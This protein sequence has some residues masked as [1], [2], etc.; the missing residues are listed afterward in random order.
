MKGDELAPAALAVLKKGVVAQGD[1]RS[2]AFRIAAVVYDKFSTI[3]VD[4]EILKAAATLCKAAKSEAVVNI[5]FV[6]AVALVL[7]SNVF[8]GEKI[9][10]DLYS[11][12][13]INDSINREKIYT[14]FAGEGSYIYPSDLSVLR[15]HFQKE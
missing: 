15:C 13:S 2:A 14:T 3:P 5:D 11:T 1:K 12:L 6:P 10:A 7:R 8:N 9:D 4:A